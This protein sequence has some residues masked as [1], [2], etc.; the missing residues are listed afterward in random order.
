MIIKFFNGFHQ[1]EI[2]FLDEIQKRHAAADITFG[3]ADHQAGIGLDQMFPR[4][5][6]VFDQVL[7]DQFPF[8]GA[9][10]VGAV[11]FLFARSASL[12]AAGDIE[13]LVDLQ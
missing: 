13:F 5:N 9:T 4:Q 10:A 3:H 1:A 8:G 12:N 7:K 11:Q 6:A 2:A